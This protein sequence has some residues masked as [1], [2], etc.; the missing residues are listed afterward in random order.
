MFLLQ[1]PLQK[2]LKKVFTDHRRIIFNGNGYDENWVKEAKKR[3]LANLVSTAD[4][5]P[6]YA[7]PK[8]VKLYGDNNIYTE[9]EL[10]A[11]AVIHM[12]TYNTTI[13]IEARTMIDMIA[14]DI[15]P[16]ASAFSAELCDRIAAKQGAGL[17]A[18]YET[19]LAKEL[20]QLTDLLAAANEKL[21]KDMERI[22]AEPDKAMAYIHHTILAD[23]AKA[24]DYADR[25]EAGTDAEYWPFPTYSELMFS[26]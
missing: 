24:R 15:L 11:R 20:S 3:G 5:L 2:L 14:H 25:L 19:G 23:M 21:S 7:C 26:E 8:N 17:E 4:A 1:K 12:E 6:Y 16:A 22:P 13:E 18:K 9:E 10:K